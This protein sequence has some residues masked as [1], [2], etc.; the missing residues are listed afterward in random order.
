LFFFIVAFGN[1]SL[2]VTIDEI[3]NVDF[4]GTTTY[5][6]TKKKSLITKKDPKH[7]IE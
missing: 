5:S 7:D 3:F 4:S 2:S 1:Y 6:E